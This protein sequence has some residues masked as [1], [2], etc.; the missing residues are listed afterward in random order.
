MAVHG[1]AKRIN[2][3]QIGNAPVVLIREGRTWRQCR[4][5]GA[6]MVMMGILLVA[7]PGDSRN[8]SI[9]PDSSSAAP[10]LGLARPMR[11]PNVPLWERIRTDVAEAKLIKVAVR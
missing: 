10:R 3:E 9:V 11:N 4:A 1:C 7:S 6:A 8:L 2:R 5:S